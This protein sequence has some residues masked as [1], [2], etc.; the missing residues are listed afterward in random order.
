VP[1]QNLQ[2]RGLSWA[3]LEREA[4]ELVGTPFAHRGRAPAA[5]DC[6]GLVAVL[7]RRTFGIRLPDYAADG[8]AEHRGEASALIATERDAWLEIPAGRERPGDVVLMRRFGQPLHVGVVLPG[9]RLVHAD[10]PAGVAIERYTAPQLR[11]RVLGFYRHPQ[12]V[13]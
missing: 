10:E 3:L 5:L 7:Y 12:A 1:V 8:S 4:S 11:D 2:P 13:G 6:W 9:R